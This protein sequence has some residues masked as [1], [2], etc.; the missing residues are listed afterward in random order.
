[1][2]LENFV[3]QPLSLCQRYRYKRPYFPYRITS[4][5]SRWLIT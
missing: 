4:C 1:M 3:G 2:K 5:S